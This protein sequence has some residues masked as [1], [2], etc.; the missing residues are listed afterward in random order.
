MSPLPAWSEKTVNQLEAIMLKQPNLFILTDYDGTLVPI[1]KRPELAVPNSTLL[2]CIE[3]LAAKNNILVGIVSGRDLDQLKELIPIDGIYMV[4][5]HGAE[6]MHPSGERSMV[7]GIEVLS[8]ILDLIADRTLKL[9]LE[10]RGFLVE[11]KKTAVTLHYRLADPLIVLNVIE[12]FKALVEPF[13]KEHNLEIMEGKKVIELRMIGV[14][15]GKAVRNLIRLN[16]GY[17]PVYFGDDI[18]DEDAFK[19]VREYG[20]G[21]LIS[22]SPR[23]TSASYR[24]YGPE[25]LIMLLQVVSGGVNK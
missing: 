7:D 4:G 14:N 24:L 9:A 13:L 11:R 25:E 21:V 8:P 6:Y 17:Y 18:T 22:E 3:R 19:D 20:T 1:E 15:K 23:D 10:E 5:C 2:D 16:K 12:N